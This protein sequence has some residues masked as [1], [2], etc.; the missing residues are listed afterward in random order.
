MAWGLLSGEQPLDD[1]RR[2]EPLA[3]PALHGPRS[4]DRAD[5]WTY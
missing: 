1:D 3:V 2:P 4:T 5:G